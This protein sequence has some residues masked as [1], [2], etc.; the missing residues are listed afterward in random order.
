[1]K[2]LARRKQPLSAAEAAL[3]GIVIL[4]L[5]ISLVHG[6]AHTRAN[7]TLSPAST[8]FVVSI[9]LIGPV[10][11]WG[12]HRRALPRGGAWIVAASLCGA[13]VFGLANHFLIDGVDHVRHVAEP[14]RAAFGVTA[15]L[16]AVTEAAGLAAAVWCATRVRGES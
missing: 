13:L 7:V 15:A 11:G 8:A 14:W 9:I 4:H 2:P 6:F 5:G 10:F 16:L 3:T 1:M 12:L